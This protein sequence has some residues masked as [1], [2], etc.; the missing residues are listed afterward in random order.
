MK[1]YSSPVLL[2]LLHICNIYK[3]V[4]TIFELIICNKPCFTIFS[5]FQ[6]NAY[7]ENKQNING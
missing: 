3:Q 2:Q 4:L 5:M 1:R 6:C 7:C